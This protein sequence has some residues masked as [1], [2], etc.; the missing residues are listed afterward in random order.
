MVSTGKGRRYKDDKYGL[1]CK[2]VGICD[3]LS[4]IGLLSYYLI[5]I[6]VACHEFSCI[7]D[8]T[9]TA[10]DSMVQSIF[11]NIRFLS[12]VRKL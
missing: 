2:Q 5:C 3:R 1:Y 4:K 8:S 12:R 6:A 9:L 11:I 7:R 10:N